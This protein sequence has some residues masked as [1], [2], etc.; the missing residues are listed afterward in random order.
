VLHPQE[1]IARP[2]LF[3]LDRDGVVR[4]N[5]IGMSASDRPPIDEI[6]S[7]LRALQ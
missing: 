3:I 6:L 5:Y 7:Q 1:G 4:W 2:A